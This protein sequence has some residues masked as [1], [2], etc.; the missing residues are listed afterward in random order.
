MEKNRK[1]GVYCIIWVA[2]VG[3][4]LLIALVAQATSSTFNLISYPNIESSPFTL[5]RSPRNI[6][7]GGWS[8]GTQG[9]FGIRELRETATNRKIVDQLIL[10]HFLAEVGIFD[11]LYLGAD[12]PVVWSN[13]FQDPTPVIAP[14]LT[15]QTDLGDLRLELKGILLD[16]DN[17]A[18]GLALVPYV[19]I[20]TGNDN[21]FVG[22]SKVV[23]GAILALDTTL[24]DR[25]FLGFNGG[26][27]YL[28]D[29]V[30]FRNIQ[31][32]HLLLSASAGAGY[33]LVPNRWDIALEGNTM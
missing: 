25:L 20:P 29:P 19:Q 33:H 14:G 11:W 2:L 7:Q 3:V 4:V 10:Q 27:A 31:R 22:N 8:L 26:V 5:T 30:D 1:R 23:G 6:G 13:R 16:P 17:F 18:L 12:F 32:N 9:I 24:W 15:R 21:H 28:K